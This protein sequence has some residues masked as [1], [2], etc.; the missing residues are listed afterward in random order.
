MPA[1]IRDQEVVL[2]KLLLPMRVLVKPNV[3]SRA[4]I[5]SRSVEILKYIDGNQCRPVL[6]DA[7]DVKTINYFH[8]DDRAKSEIESIKITDVQVFIIILVKIS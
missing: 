1:A 3:S 4:C 7:Q 6:R 8:T 5:S 2:A